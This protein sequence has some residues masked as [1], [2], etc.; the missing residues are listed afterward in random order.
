MKGMVKVTGW[1]KMGNWLQLT[2]QHNLVDS[3][4]LSLSLKSFDA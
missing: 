3:F 1:W 4:V 2:L